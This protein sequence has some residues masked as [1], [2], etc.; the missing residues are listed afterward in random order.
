[1]ANDITE[2]DD[3]LNHK[4]ALIVN[5]E[6]IYKLKHRKEQELEFYQKQLE[7]LQFRMSMI[8]QEIRL[9][10]TILNMIKEERVVDLAEFHKDKE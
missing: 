6:D 8:S 10:E 4:P 7:K 1:M 2:P 3:D 9:T 5:I